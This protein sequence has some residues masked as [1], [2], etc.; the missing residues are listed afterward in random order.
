MAEAVVIDITLRMLDQTG[1]GLDRTRGSSDRLGESLRRTQQQADR[2]GRSRTEVKLSTKDKITQVLT[3]VSNSLK[4]I[5][6]KTWNVTVK[7]LDKA[8]APLRGI[9]NM[10]KNPIVQAGAVIGVS[11]GAA[12]AFNTFKDFEKSMSNVK[13]LSGANEKQ[14]AELTAKARE[15]G[16]TTTKSA[17]EA[18]DA[19][20]YMALAG[21][22]A[23]IMDVAIEPTLRLSEAGDMDLGRTSDLVTDSMSSLGLGA[24][25]LTGY[26]DKVAR[27]ASKSN[28]DIDQ[29]MES[30]LEI[31]GTVKQN[32]IPLEEASGLI[33]VL[34]NRGVKGS[35]AG[36]ALNSVLVNLTTGAGQAGKAMEKLELSAFNSDGSFKGYAETLK[37]LNEK[38]KE[39]TDEQK[40]YYLSAIGGKMRLS[41]LQKLLAGVSG[42]YDELKEKIIDSKG[43]LEDMAKTKNDNIYGDIKALQSAIDDIKITLVTKLQPEVRRFIR[44]LTNKMPDVNKAV[45]KAADFIV[46]KIDSIRK[47]VKSF[48]SSFEWNKADFFG[49]VRIA[50]DKIIAEPFGEWWSSGGKQWAAGVSESIGHGIGSGLKNGILL[51]LGIDLDQATNDGTSI[52]KSFAEGFLEGFDAEK[53]WSAVIEKFKSMFSGAIKVLPGGDSPTAG[54]WLSAA[55]LGGAALKIG[56]LGKG[57]LFG[58]SLAGAAGAGGLGGAG[59]ATGGLIGVIGSAAKGT[60]ILGFGVKT[61]GNL[62]IGSLLG[63]GTN[64]SGLALSRGAMSALGLGSIASIATALTATIA[65]ANDLINGQ[66]ERGVTKLGMVGTGALL[67][68]A[69]GSFVP[70]IGNVVGGILG[71]GIGGLGALIGG[72]KIGDWIE[73][74]RFRTEK[75]QLEYDQKKEAE[76]KVTQEKEKQLA[77]EKNIA[78]L[79]STRSQL[80]EANDRLYEVNKLKDKYIDLNKEI[81]NGE[82]TEEQKLEKQKEIKNLVSEI[83]AL[84]PGMVSESDAENGKLGEKL[85]LLQNISA[86]EK[87]RAKLQLD[88]AL[89]DAR[90]NY[91]SMKENYESSS[92]NIEDLKG[93]SNNFNDTNFLQLMEKAEK[94]QLLEEKLGIAIKNGNFKERDQ[95]IEKIGKTRD[96]IN[97]KLA[98]IGVVRPDDDRKYSYTVDEIKTEYLDAEYAVKDKLVKEYEINDKYKNDSTAAYSNELKRIELELGRPFDEAYEKLDEMNKAQKD[99]FVATLK[100]MKELMKEFD[101]LPDKKY[102]DIILQMQFDLSR[103]TKNNMFGTSFDVAANFINNDMNVD[104]AMNEFTDKILQ[105]FTKFQYATGGIVDKPHIGLIGEAGPEAIIPLSGS[106]RNIGKSLWKKTGAMLGMFPKHASGGIFGVG[107]QDYAKDAVPVEEVSAESENTVVVTSG[108]PTINLGDINF[109]FEVNGNVD[110]ENV[111]QI[112]YQHLPELSDEILK[113]IAEASKKIIPNM[114]AGLI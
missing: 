19:M 51:L 10:L 64:L 79:K 111:M 37:E 11:L 24:D 28:T 107:K 101:Y 46:D 85:N 55:L 76:R 9:F 67:G 53:V 103:M 31:G 30:F 16:R 29:L 96:E 92:K 34:A 50:W 112:I 54:S 7:V 80:D 74:H 48:T 4:K 35:E 90:K 13:A 73:E 58:S 47:T 20:G 22:D 91:D 61:A 57:L 18:A 77:I 40:S 78:K 56:K 97:Q 106:N 95:L 70:V 17:S 66:V 71:A 104:N 23:K 109:K 98:E 84:Y 89:Y 44:W 59:A 6:G 69:A 33:G 15:M 94:E 21:W 32:N 27:T 60:G 68:A 114:K 36:V 1:Q 100:K 75:E 86:T 63:S 81:K 88:T 12:D 52:G 49:K 110:R 41:D 3:K 108:S 39:M 105:N 113:I 62:G 14:M 102:V 5:V 8:T 43:A 26:L 2:L 65:G 25:E 45:E 72:N 93:K 82:L 42:E 99:A 87:E 83:A 38:T